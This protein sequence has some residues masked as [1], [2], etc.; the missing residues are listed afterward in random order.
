MFIYNL[1]E[2]VE[3]SKCSASDRIKFRAFKCLEQL[4]IYGNKKKN[5]L[6]NAI[7]NFNNGLKYLNLSDCSIHKQELECLAKS[8]HAQTLLQLNLIQNDIGNGSD[9]GHLPQ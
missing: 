9:I 3:N 8:K 5:G 7:C 1:N 2:R 4:V 6:V